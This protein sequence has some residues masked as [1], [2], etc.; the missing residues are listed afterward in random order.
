MR[1]S[2][3]FFSLRDEIEFLLARWFV[4]SWKIVVKTEENSAQVTSAWGA[5]SGIYVFLSLSSQT[6]V[7]TWNTEHLVTETVNAKSRAT[8]LN[9]RAIQVQGAWG[10]S[11]LHLSR[12]D[13]SLCDT[14]IFII[15]AG[16]HWCTRPFYPKAE[17][18]MNKMKLQLSRWG[19]FLP[20]WLS[21]CMPSPGEE[22][23]ETKREVAQTYSR[24][25]FWKPWF[26]CFVPRNLLP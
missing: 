7:F 18:L 26:L 2:L 12:I 20:E 4:D 11:N 15:P 3:S 17:T 1:E 25:L 6:T 22:W 10:P 19:D 13:P 5:T 21:E 8:L 23:K 9:S 24:K 16:R 14:S